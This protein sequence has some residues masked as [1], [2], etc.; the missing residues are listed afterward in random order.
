MSTKPFDSPERAGQMLSIPA[1]AAILLYAGTLAAT[2]ANGRAVPAS[3][4]AGL[5][6][7]GRVEEDADNSAGL[8]GAI[9]ARIKKSTFR[10]ANSAANALDQA[11]VGKRCYVEDDTTVSA[12]P[13]DNGIIAG[14]LVAVDAEG[15]WVDTSKATLLQDLAAAEARVTDLENA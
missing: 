12:D 9:N 3:D 6:V 13:G 2:D 5:R 8:A 11:D 1:A 10:F 14:E 15:A 7:R 4:T